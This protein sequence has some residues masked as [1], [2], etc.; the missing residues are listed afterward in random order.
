MNRISKMYLPCVDID[1]IHA[2]DERHGLAVVTLCSLIP[3][4]HECVHSSSII[5][6]NIGSSLEV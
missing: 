6:A 5:T 3:A 2:Q 1:F 4:A